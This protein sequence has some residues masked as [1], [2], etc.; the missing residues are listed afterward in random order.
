MPGKKGG[1]PHRAEDY[2]VAMKTPA[3]SPAPAAVPAKWRSHHQAL[4][5][6]REVLLAERS[7]RET[8][9]RAPHERGGT[10]AM[11]VASS[12]SESGELLAELNAERAELVE[13][14]AA[15]ARLAAGTYGLCEATGTPISPERLLALPWTRLSAAAAKKRETPRV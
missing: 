13:V 6:L 2:S 1:A 4:T 7:S 11:D 14:E 9:L 3:S 12:E 8:A 10:D 15:L 5:R